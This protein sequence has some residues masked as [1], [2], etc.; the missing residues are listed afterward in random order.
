[1]TSPDLSTTLFGKRFKNPLILGSGTLVERPDQITPYIADGAALVV[2]RTTRAVM[3]RAT[4]PIPHLWQEGRRADPNFFNSEWT[5]AD[6]DFWRPTLAEHLQSGN[7]VMSVSGRDIEG[8]LR[9]CQELDAYGRWPYI[10]VNISCAHSNY[11]HSV[12]N[13]DIEHTKR[14][15]GSLYNLRL[16][17]PIAL[18]LGYSAALME[19]CRCAHDEGIDGLVLLNTFGP[20]FHFDIN[21]QGEAVRTSGLSG[22]M[23]GL[24]GAPLFPIALDAV[25]HAFHETR[26]PIVA[27]GGVSSGREAL[28]MLMAGAQAVQVYSAAHSLGERGPTVFARILQD[29]RKLLNKYQ[30]SRLDDI[31]GAAVPIMEYKT[32]MEKYVP[33]VLD[34]H[35]IGCGI[36]VEI[37]LPNAITE[38]ERDNSKSDLKT[39]RIDNDTCVGCGH[40]IPVCPTGIRALQWDLPS[41]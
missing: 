23:S 22:S 36:C 28:Q 6:I 35:C 29:L 4:H 5:G 33:T 11:A 10:E 17:S 32:N 1:M 38:I 24:S 12:I 31:I 26:L 25:A 39:V 30:V 2:P 41:D 7:V 40:C 37:C 9:V 34:D 15:V 13:S 27:C 21:S 16:Q 20:V 3:E 14:L 18:K 8:C 19:M